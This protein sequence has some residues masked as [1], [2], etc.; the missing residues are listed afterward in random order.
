[1]PANQV[2]STKTSTLTPGIVLTRLQQKVSMVNAK[3]M[4]DSAKVQV[5]LQV[6]GN[7]TV[8]EAEQA[9]ALCLKLINNG[10]PSFH[11]GQALYKE[12]VM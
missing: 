5:G 9:K 4:L 10:G 7:D 8:L 1:M 6:I 3:I 11:V 2:T 12:Y